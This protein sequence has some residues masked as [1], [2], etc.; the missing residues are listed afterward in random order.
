MHFNQLIP[1][2]TFSYT[3]LRSFLNEFSVLTPELS[4]GE[5][6]SYYLHFL[7]KII[8]PKAPHVI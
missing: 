2:M 7:V 5:K 6:K 4:Q 1:S 8:I 3:P